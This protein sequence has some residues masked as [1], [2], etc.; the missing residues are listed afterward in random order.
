L[1]PNKSQV[2]AFLLVAALVFPAL[3][4]RG[5]DANESPEAWRRTAP[6]SSAENY[7]AHAARDGVSIGA[8]LL[9]R[10][11]VS[12]AFAADLNRCC[13]VVQVAVY[14]KTD[15]AL[16]LSRDDFTLDVKGSDTTVRPMS[17]SEISAR[18]Q[19]KTNSNVP[20]ITSASGEIG[21]EVGTYPDPVTGQPVHGHAV[22]T[23]VNV[24]AASGR[25][26][27]PAATEGDREAIERQ[28]NEKGL[29]QTRISVPVSGYLY[30]LLP[31]RK[32]D[33]KYRLQY[34]VK[35]ESLILPLP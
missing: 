32:N 16:N 35:G 19:K 15:E 18:L 24:A 33:A 31:K 29:P 28:L 20:V 34:V 14:P 12:K 30:F 7:K 10:K 26:V 4:F 17:S 9:T 3:L 13:V 23:S 25:V 5:Q 27:S 21:Y 11:E 1:R 8:E 22:T 2:R 6:R